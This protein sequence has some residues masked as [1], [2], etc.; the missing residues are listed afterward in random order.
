[1]TTGRTYNVRG[2]IFD[3]RRFCVN[4][5]PGIRTTVFFKGCPLNCRWCHNPE[6]QVPEPETSEKTM[7]LDGF[8]FALNETTGRWMYADEILEEAK[9]DNIFYEESGGGVCLSGGEPFN[10]PEFL[11][12]LLTLLK[13]DNLNIAVDTSGYADWKWMEKALEYTDLFLYDLKI[14]DESLHVRHTGASNKPI[15]ANLLK[16]ARHTEKILIR[17]PVVP[18]INDN[19]GHF[20]SLASFLYPIRSSIKE[21]NLLPYH[22]LAGKKYSRLGRKDFMKNTLDLPKEALAGR[23][24]DFERMGFNVKIGG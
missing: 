23:M 2:L 8:R 13:F 24:A 1:M 11:L 7:A 5:G 9:K 16:L 20:E 6:S 17:L 4:D 12:E 14:M 19:D 10:Q 3:I 15:L 18:G 22:S 21:I